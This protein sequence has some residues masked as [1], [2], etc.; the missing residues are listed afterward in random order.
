LTEKSRLAS[1][2]FAAIVLATAL[3]A[4]ALLALP[5]PAASAH[6]CDNAR[7]KPRS[8]STGEARR[9]VHCLLDKRRRAHGLPSLRLTASLDRAA[10]DHS[11]YM[12]RHG[13]FSHQC[14]GEPDLTGRLRRTRYL[15]SGLHA[16]SYGEDIAW[17]KGYRPSQPVRIVRDWMHSP[18]HR[19]NILDGGFR[20]L[21][22][23]VY[24]GTP[25][26]AHTGGIFTID[27]GSRSG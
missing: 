27:F 18:P 5:A 12:A 8:I 21:G 23:G 9:A 4:L 1:G 20:D 22:V 25:Y 10:R 14:P 15:R 16:W 19:A 2:A 17:A 6:P 7:A 11:R 3:G 24:W 13:C 26:G